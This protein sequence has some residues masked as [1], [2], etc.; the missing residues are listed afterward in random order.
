MV[1]GIKTLNGNWHRWQYNVPGSATTN[2]F[3]T[4]YANTNQ[5]VVNGGSYPVT[6]NT[7]LLASGIIAAATV[8]ASS[9]NGSTGDYWYSHSDASD[10]IWY[11][12]GR[13]SNGANAGLF[14][15][16]VYSAPSGADSNLGARLAKV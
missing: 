11:H 12:G 6:F 14:Y 4:G 15:A 2:D 3:S 10:L 1:D 5:S 9:A 8:D 16:D 7:A 13:W